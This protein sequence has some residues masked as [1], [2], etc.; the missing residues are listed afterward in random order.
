[1][2]KNSLVVLSSFWLPFSKSSNTSNLVL[3]QKLQIQV[4]ESIIT[5]LETKGKQFLIALSHFFCTSKRFSKH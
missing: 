2:S 3:V 1:M 4:F 5:V